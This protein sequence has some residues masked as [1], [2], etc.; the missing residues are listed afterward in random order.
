MHITGLCYGKLEAAA[1]FFVI[2]SVLLGRLVN[3]LNFDVCW[4][5]CLGF[6]SQEL[7]YIVDAHTHVGLLEFEI[8][9]EIKVFCHNEGYSILFFLEAWLRRKQLNLFFDLEGELWVMC[10]QM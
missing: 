1:L 10:L 3:F 8:E 9:V 5:E 2:P 6:W 4:E 7:P